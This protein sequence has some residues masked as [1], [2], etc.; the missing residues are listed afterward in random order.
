M[1]R[2]TKERRSTPSARASRKTSTTSFDFMSMTGVPVEESIRNWRDLNVQ[3]YDKL[4]VHPY[5]RCRAILMNGIETNAT[6]MS[7]NFSRMTADP[8]VKS[9]LSM[10]RRSDSQHQ[11]YI[12]WMHPAD[13]T[14][15]EATIGYEQLAVDLTADLARKE[16][17]PYFKQLLDY[18]LLEDFDHLFRYGCLLELIEGKDPNELTW[19]FTEVKP[20]RPTKIEH[21][22]PIDEMRKP[23]DSKKTDIKTK[24]N[25]Y[26][27]VSGEQ[28]TMLY[29]KSHGL[30][31][32]QEPARGLYTEIAEIEQ[33]HVSQ[34]EDG[35]DPHE[36]MLEKMALMEL[37]EAYLYFSH[38]Q[39]E[40]D[41]R[42]QK[43]WMRL[44]EEEIGH[45]RACAELMQKFEGRDIK[46]VLR[47]ESIPGLVVLESQ[48]DY[49]NHILETQ[50]DLRPFNMEFVPEDQLPHDWPSWNYQAKVN[51]GW[52]PSESVV[53]EAEGKDK[54]PAVARETE[55]GT[56]DIF[57]RLKKDHMEVRGMLEKLASDG[58]DGQALF[59]KLKKELTSHSRAEE[60]I[61]YDGL[62]SN[63]IAKEA[64]LE[65]YEEHH[66]A[67][68]FMGELSRNKAGTDQW[69]AKV[70]VLMDMVEHH[71]VEE[72]GKLFQ[73][74]RSVF[75]AD[76]TRQ[77]VGEFEKEKKK[78]G[79]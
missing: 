39:T 14:V 36:T 23:S 43:I 48:K 5:T 60:K 56:A 38:A 70:K 65:G 53:D 42:F 17:D 67:D 35:G 57:E 46:E 51:S 73:K 9:M 31:Y 2:M 33:Q 50:L 58:G 75:D 63:P 25:Y 3:P 13:Q 37:C 16:P 12:N 69:K 41:P 71:V 32:S 40:I 7:H 77:M 72:E 54:V 18:A 64:V 26:T 34:Y 30:Q 1:V 24:M 21:R 20:G 68:L 59:D 61:L 8:R 22:H 11:Q 19:G 55:P 10:I 79:K 49:V 4:T 76:R 28:Q 52:V 6:I 29:Y 44:C 45:F 62:K 47:A 74:A 78:V 66:A 15:A 27:I